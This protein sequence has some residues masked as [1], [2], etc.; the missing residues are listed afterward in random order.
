MGITVPLSPTKSND[1]S[2]IPQNIVSNAKLSKLSSN[3]IF[4]F[5]SEKINQ[6]AGFKHKD[7]MI[8]AVCDKYGKLV[9]GN[10]NSYHQTFTHY[11]QNLCREYLENL[12]K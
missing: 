3:V 5:N 7:Y 6:L 2:Q 11:G 9:C 4:D 8:T 10:A 12:I 1:R